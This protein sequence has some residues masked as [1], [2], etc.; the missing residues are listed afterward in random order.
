[1]NVDNVKK[2]YNHL[3][4]LKAKGEDRLFRMENYLTDLRE[5]PKPKRKYHY[6]GTTIVTKEKIETYSCKTAA[7][8]AGWSY[9][10]L[11][12][13]RIESNK[14]LSTNDIIEYAKEWLGLTQCQ[15]N[16][17]FN[18]FW[19]PHIA[20]E[21]ITLDDAIEFLK[22]RLDKEKEGEEA[23][24]KQLEEESKIPDGLVCNPR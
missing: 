3:V 20:I 1:M 14:H 6:P 8:I 11:N 24:A 4:Y 16:Y 12:N 15:A 13:N 10:L 19:K 9:Y 23:L 7:C 17:W 2:L 5:M 22:S 18:G 21:N